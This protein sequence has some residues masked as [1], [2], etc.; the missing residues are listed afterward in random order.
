M[1]VPD[2]QL[3]PDYAGRGINAWHRSMLAVPLLRSGMAI[4]VI[5]LGRAAP[6]PKDRTVLG[7]IQIYRQEVRAFSEK[8]IALRVNFSGQAVIAIENARFLNE[9][10]TALDRAETTLHKWKIAQANLVQAERMASL[11]QLTAGIAHEI[12]NRSNFVN[13]FSELSVDLLNELKTAIE[14][15][16]AALTEEQREDIED[17]SKTLKGYFESPERIFRKP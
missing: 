4:G 8:Q 17:I 6:L 2:T 15:A 13:N 3:D 7:F 14:P 10:E 9:L 5:G 12:K 11:G 16:W 1:Q